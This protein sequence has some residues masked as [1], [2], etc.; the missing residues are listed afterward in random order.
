MWVNITVY[1]ISIVLPRWGIPST[2]SDD[3]GFYLQMQ[4]KGRMT[5]PVVN[6]IPRVMFTLHYRSKKLK[7]IQSVVLVLGVI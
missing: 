6:V 7:S 4:Q 1:I 5:S 2:H 3:P